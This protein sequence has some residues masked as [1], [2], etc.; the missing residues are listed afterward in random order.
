MRHRNKTMTDALFWL[1][2]LILVECIL[3]VVLYAALE[4]FNRFF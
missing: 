1:F 4:L 2:L 3:F